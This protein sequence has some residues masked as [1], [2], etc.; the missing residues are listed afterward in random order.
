MPF[1]FS[2]ITAPII[3]FGLGWVASSIYYSVK[4]IEETAT[5]HDIMSTSIFIYA[6]IAAA[7]NGLMG[8]YASD[9]EKDENITGWLG[10]GIPGIAWFFCGYLLPVSPGATILNYI[11]CLGSMLYFGYRGWD[12]IFINHI[13]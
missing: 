13:C 4:P 2:I 11:L 6:C 8:L 7:Y 12:K 5:I 1:I 3:Y 9:S 10:L